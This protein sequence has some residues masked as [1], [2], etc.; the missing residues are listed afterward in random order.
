MTDGRIMNDPEI[1]DM[2]KRMS[3]KM[4][5][6]KGDPSLADD[7]AQELFIIMRGIKKGLSH[8]AIYVRAWSR[9]FDVSRSRR[10]VYSYSDKKPHISL[11]AALLVTSS[12]AEPNVTFETTQPTNGRSELNAFREAFADHQDFEMIAIDRMI[13][14]EL[15]SSMKKPAEKLMIRK[16]IEGYTDEEIASMLGLSRSAV[17]KIRSRRL[18]KQRIKAAKEA[19]DGG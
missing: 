12:E 13:L 4:A 9:L 18:V 19:W 8:G 10:Y 15:E 14:N 1:Q 6:I 5:R 11:E 7:F 3:R 17:A 2:I 16:R